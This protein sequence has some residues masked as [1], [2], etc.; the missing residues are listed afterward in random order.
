MSDD[1][2][3]IERMPDGELTPRERQE[4][5][6]TNHKIINTMVSSDEIRQWGEKVDNM[7]WA[8]GWLVL[9][10]RNWKALGIAATLIIVIGG[11]DLLNLLL[12]KAIGELE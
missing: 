5:R 9:T 8:I 6:V 1:K 3:L 10:L 2:S 11:Q 12:Q 7:W 4:T